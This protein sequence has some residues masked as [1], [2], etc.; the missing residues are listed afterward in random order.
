MDRKSLNGLLTAV[1]KTFLLAQDNKK[2]VKVLA[3]YNITQIFF[4]FNQKLFRQLFG[5]IHEAILPSK[6]I[7]L[8]C[9][10]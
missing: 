4:C 9:H 1:K 6:N 7:L 5:N 10:Y 8:G 2:T 3:V